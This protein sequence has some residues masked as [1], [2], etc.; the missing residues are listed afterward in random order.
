M[1]LCPVCCGMGNAEGGG[2][3]SVISLGWADA[4]YSLLCFVMLV[5]TSCHSVRLVVFLSPL[6]QQWR[7]VGRG[8]C[9]FIHFVSLHG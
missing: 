4:V 6:V 8:G 1:G 2:F 7:V 3:P 9:S 5:S